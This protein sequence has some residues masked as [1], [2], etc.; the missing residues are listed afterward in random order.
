MP[1]KKTIEEIEEAET[2]AALL[3]L[4]ELKKEQDHLKDFLKTCPK[5]DRESI[6]NTID[7]LDNRIAELSRHKFGAP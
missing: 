7:L 2:K 1:T 6:S 5:E 4:D 3:G